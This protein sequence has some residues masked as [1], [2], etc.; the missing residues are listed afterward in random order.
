M[1]SQCFMC[2]LESAFWLN[3][4]LKIHPSILPEHSLYHFSGCPAPITLMGR[5]SPTYFSCWKRNVK[6]SFFTFVK[7]K[8]FLS[9]TY[10]SVWLSNNPVGFNKDDFKL[11]MVLNMRKEAPRGA[12]GNFFSILIIHMPPSHNTVTYQKCH[13]FL[14]NPL[15]NYSWIWFRRVANS[16]CRHLKRVW[17]ADME[18]P[19][20]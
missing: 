4:M 15:A 20:F 18:H 6:A 19:P 11:C 10:F 5:V 16:K 9:K 14:T 7:T 2:N 1:T 13:K 17:W 8:V 3:V 12:R